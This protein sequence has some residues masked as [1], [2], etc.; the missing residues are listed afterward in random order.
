MWFSYQFTLSGIKSQER[1][2]VIVSSFL[3]AVHFSPEQMIC[4]CGLLTCQTFLEASTSPIKAE[5]YRQ[6]SEA[7]GMCVSEV[8]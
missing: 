2:K 4:I 7:H 8:R 6:A 5:T 1:A 3:E